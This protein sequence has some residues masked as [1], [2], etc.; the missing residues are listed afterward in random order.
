MVSPTV[1]GKFTVVRNGVEYEFEP[2]DEGGYVVS[3]P[4]YPSCG[5]QGE[6]FEEALANIEDALTETLAA[7]KDL[8]LEVPP[9]LASSVER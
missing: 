3:V 2:A 6:N 8:G 9:D 5:S 7:A 1:R 4:L